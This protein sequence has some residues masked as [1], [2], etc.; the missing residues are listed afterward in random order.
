MKLTVKGGGLAGGLAL[1]L[2]PLAALGAKPLDFQALDQVTAAGVNPRHHW[3]QRE[4]ETV[5]ARGAAADISMLADV[6]L[7]DSVQTDARALNIHNAAAADSVS[8]LNVATLSRNGSGANA[9]NDI[10]QENRL[11]QDA[12]FVGRLGSIL[13][14]GPDT[15][16]TWN[17]G[18]RRSTRQGVTDGYIINDRSVVTRNEQESLIAVV[19]QWDPTKD[20]TFDLGSWSA[21][22]VDLGT[23]RVGGI[24]DTDVGD[25]GFEVSTGPAELT[26]PSIN[27]GRVRFLNDD[28]IL[29]PG[30]FTLPE[31]D[32]GTASIEICVAGCISS[33][34]NLGTVGGSQIGPLDPVTLAD[35]N[36]FKDWDLQAGSGIALIGSG[37]VSMTG[38]GAY[39]DLDF[40]LDINDFLDLEDLMGDTITREVS[41][42]KAGTTFTETFRVDPADYFGSFP[43]IRL[44]ERIVL[45]EPGPEQTFD[46][47][48]DGFCIQFGGSGC[49]AERLI[50]TTVTYEND[51]TT[52]DLTSRSGSTQMEYWRQESEL[53]FV[54]A[55]MKGAQA[56]MIVMSDASL[57]HRRNNNT[58]LNQSAQRNLRALNAVNASNAVIGNLNNMITHQNP[59]G[60]SA[61][62][63]QL[64]RFIQR[65]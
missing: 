41:G 29:Q 10:V 39:I 12:F 30:H 13:A 43:S 17:I 64:N 6:I 22:S 19:P 47:P 60:S 49:Q 35:A 20:F 24:A 27:F 63:T 5:V 25:Y 8:L 21:G 38:P 62:Q 33:S 51:H 53:V 52:V 7:Q 4:G 2:F 1:S 37:E 23:L 65:R 34:S 11:Q 32:F 55:S 40:V 31:V 54:P 58:L 9:D 26:G 15:L 42:S 44:Q 14:D 18:F 36:P 50:T 59:A 16:H 57:T 61:R 56:D 48:E 46:I 45:L 3:I 28:I